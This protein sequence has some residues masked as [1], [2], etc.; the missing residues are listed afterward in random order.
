MNKNNYKNQPTTETTTTPSSS[1]P[2]NNDYKKW[3]IDQVYEWSQNQED[4]RKYAENLKQQEIKGIDLESLTYN[5]LVKE[6]LKFSAGSA[7]SL[8]RAIQQLTG[9][10]KNQG[11]C[12]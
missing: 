2:I 10:S 11:I 5:E 12:Y 6:P 7:K 1:T 4:I 8:L 9:N 3:T